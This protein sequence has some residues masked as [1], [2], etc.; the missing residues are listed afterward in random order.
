M[1]LINH[2]LDKSKDEKENN[3]M[4]ECCDFLSSM[5][6]KDK[7]VVEKCVKN[8]TTLFMHTKDNGDKIKI[9]SAVNFCYNKSC[10]YINYLTTTPTRYLKN[11][12]IHGDDETFQKRGV[13]SFLLN[14]V[15][16]ICEGFHFNN[17]TPL[18]MILQFSTDDPDV[19]K[20]YKNRG[21]SIPDNKD[22]IE[23]KLSKESKE[24]NVQYIHIVKA[25]DMALGICKNKLSLDKGE[26]M[27]PLNLELFVLSS[28]TNSAEKK[29][30]LSH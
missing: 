4:K 3:L 22:I 1:T 26:K 2:V 23:D 30:W 24:S 13:A 21:F 12:Y 27:A 8:A 28:P 9:I 7:K 17:G 25:S 10:V 6:P 18:Q 20:Y 14:L 15:W 16:E 5:F 19:P 11:I 29:M